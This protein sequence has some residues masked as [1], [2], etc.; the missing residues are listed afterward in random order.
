[1]RLVQSSRRTANAEQVD[2]VLKKHSASLRTLYDKYA[3]ARLGEQDG[4][5]GKPT[6]MSFDEWMRLCKDL[7]LFDHE[8]TYRC[9][10]LC[11]V[12]C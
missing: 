5:L 10:V 7:Q 11:F 2:A 6:L 3:D 1:M 8:F 12:W 4:G 9:A